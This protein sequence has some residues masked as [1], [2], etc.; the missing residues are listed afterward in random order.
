MEGGVR[1]VASKYGPS[2]LAEYSRAVRT[3]GALLLLEVA[4]E[5]INFELRRQHGFTEGQAALV[6]KDKHKHAFKTDFDDEA[7]K[8]M[9]RHMDTKVA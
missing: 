3:A 6:I 1:A 4:P 9:F 5:A 8:A 2:P 7:R